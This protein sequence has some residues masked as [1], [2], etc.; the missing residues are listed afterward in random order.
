MW[1]IP[2]QCES[3]F[4]SAV[5]VSLVLLGLHHFLHAKLLDH[6]KLTRYRSLRSVSYNL[7]PSYSLILVYP[8][9]TATLSCLSS[10]NFPVFLCLL[11]YQSFATL[12]STIQQFC[13]DTITSNSL[14][15]S[16][17][18]SST[19]IRFFPPFV[20]ALWTFYLSSHWPIRDLHR[21]IISI[22]LYWLIRF[23]E[24]YIT[25]CA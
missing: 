9:S 15:S 22:I 11:H 20:R 24:R 5:V 8:I 3:W 1:Y 14:R 21:M 23:L 2:P 17:I 13:F 12:R 18:N 6:Y 25:A 10:H 19:E 16:I 4:F 7:S